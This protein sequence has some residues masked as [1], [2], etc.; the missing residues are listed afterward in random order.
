MWVCMEHGCLSVCLCVGRWIF[1]LML[2]QPKLTQQTGSPVYQSVRIRLKLLLSAI[3]EQ[4]K[5][6]SCHLISECSV[7]KWNDVM[8]FWCYVGVDFLNWIFSAVFPHNIHEFMSHFS[9]KLQCRNVQ[10]L[11]FLCAWQ[12]QHQPKFPSASSL[13]VAWIEIPFVCPCRAS[14]YKEK[15]GFRAP[16]SSGSLIIH[17]L[18]L[19]I[20][21]HSSTAITEIICSANPVKCLCH[22]S[23]Q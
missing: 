16:G 3:T 11:R 1:S 19:W 15:H 8:F 17:A 4:N 5:S 14:I 6:G 23:Q 7:L 18:S 9:S 21:A 12:L 13:W 20:I 10:I 22:L 2:C